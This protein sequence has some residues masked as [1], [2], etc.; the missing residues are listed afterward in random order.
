MPDR[1]SEAE[2][3]AMRVELES[4]DTNYTRDDTMESR[5][6]ATLDAIKAERDEARDELLAFR[7]INAEGGSI[8]ATMAGDVVRTLALALTKTFRDSKAANYLEMSVVATDGEDR[9]TVTVQRVAGDTPHALR[10]K[11]EAERDAAKAER[12]RAVEAVE[13]L[14]KIEAVSLAH[15]ASQESAHLLHALLVEIPELARTALAR[16]GKGGA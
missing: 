2:V 14:R 5:W 3:E 15:H 12:D 9:F 11:A 8:D 10:R 6:L 1:Y 4:T 7:S 13:T 16:V